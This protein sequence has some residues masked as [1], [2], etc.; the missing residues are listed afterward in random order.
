MG[1]PGYTLWHYVVPYSDSVTWAFN[2]LRLEVYSRGE[3]RGPKGISLYKVRQAQGLVGTHSILDMQWLGAEPS[4][5]TV[6]PATPARLLAAW[7]APRATLAQ[8]LACIPA[9]AHVP[10]GH[11]A[12]IYDEPARTT[13]TH[14]L[15]WGASGLSDARAEMLSNIEEAAR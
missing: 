8:A 5:D 13:P 6:C 10:G 15:F 3:Y 11:Y 12:H 7:G 9:V 14:T 1:H 4:T 2:K